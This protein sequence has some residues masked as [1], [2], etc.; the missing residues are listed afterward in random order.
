MICSPK[1]TAK[2]GTNNRDFHDGRQMMCQQFYL[3]MHQHL[4]FPQRLDADNTVD[5]CNVNVGQA[6]LYGQQYYLS[7]FDGNRSVGRGRWYKKSSLNRH[8]LDRSAG[9]GKTNVQA[10]VTRLRSEMMLKT[11]AQSDVH[12]SVQGHVQICFQ[13]DASG[14]E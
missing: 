5:S 7:C 8:T 1:G 3:L 9:S 13:P 10:Y 14:M 6:Q 11:N 2:E 12:L 4:A